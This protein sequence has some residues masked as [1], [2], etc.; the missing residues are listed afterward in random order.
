M[1]YVITVIA[2]LFLLSGCAARRPGTTG[3]A[4]APRVQKVQKSPAEELEESKMR[5]QLECPRGGAEE[6]D[7]AYRLAHQGALF[8]RR[9]VVMRVFNPYPN[10]IDIFD[11]EGVVVKNL[12]SYGSI[13]LI[14]RLN[15]FVGD[16]N[17]MRVFWTARGLDKHGRA[18]YDQS[19]PVYLNASDTYRTRENKVWHIRLRAERQTF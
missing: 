19:Q 7:I 8:N 6:V 14:R 12:C 10:Q 17:Y 1:K 11:E 2:A 9:F 3:A 4:R 5:L 16:G 15:V 18:G 13:S